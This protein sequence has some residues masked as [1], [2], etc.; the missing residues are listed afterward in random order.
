[1][2]RYVIVAINKVIFIIIKLKKEKNLTTKLVLVDRQ[3]KT[4]YYN[5]WSFTKNQN[6]IDIKKSKQDM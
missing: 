2:L 1:M 5:I 4:V 3:E 6:L